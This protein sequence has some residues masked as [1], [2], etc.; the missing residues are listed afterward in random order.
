MQFSATGLSRSA[1]G[2]A[3]Y[4]SM[5]VTGLATAGSAWAGAFTD[6]RLTASSLASGATNVTYTL[7][8]TIGTPL[9]PY[10]FLLFAETPLG[11]VSLPFENGNECFA[12]GVT[13][14]IDGVLQDPAITGL[15]CSIETTFPARGNLYFRL[16]GQAVP[17]GST[18]VITIPGGTNTA[19]L[20]GRVFPY[21]QTADGDFSPIDQ[22]SVRPSFVQAAVPSLTG[23]AAL[24]FATLLL[25]SGLGMLRRQPA[26]WPIR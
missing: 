12:A 22:A 1:I 21:F 23:W 10:D 7:I 2:S 18:F 17:A 15:G 26:R 13:V 20:T 8:Y 16:N 11:A 4:A 6:I 25:G 14:R 24:G 9:G 19:D 5:L 3:I